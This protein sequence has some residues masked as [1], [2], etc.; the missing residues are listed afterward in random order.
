MYGHLSFECEAG[1]IGAKKKKKHVTRASFRRTF[2]GKGKSSAAKP[3]AGKGKFKRKAKS[4][5]SPVK[6]KPQAKSEV[7]LRILAHSV[8]ASGK[9]FVIS[10]GFIGF[11]FWRWSLEVRA[12][13]RSGLE[14]EFV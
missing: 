13:I 1:H 7:V 2:L 10:Y 14:F 9:S 5:A 12:M 3:G 6:G 4:K 11:W 8:R